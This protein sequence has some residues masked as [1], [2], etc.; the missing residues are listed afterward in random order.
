M[1]DVSQCCFPPG[2]EEEQQG[3]AEVGIGGKLY[4]LGFFGI[5]EVCAHRSLLC[6]RRVACVCAAL[7]TTA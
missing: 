6:K 1:A 5:A 7:F 4:L 2:E 3:E